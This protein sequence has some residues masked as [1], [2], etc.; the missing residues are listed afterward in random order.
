MKKKIM[1]T[2]KHTNDVLSKA[3]ELFDV[4]PTEEK[5]LTSEEILSFATTHQVVGLLVSHGQKFDQELIE[6]LPSSVKVIAT[7]SVGFDHLDLASAKKKQIV[8][9]NTPDVLSDA[10]A[11]LTM[12]LILNVSRRARE[13]VKIMDEGWRRSFGQSE[14]LGMDLNHKTLAIFGMGAIGR[15]VAKKARAFGMKIIYCNRKRLSPELE[16]GAQYFK[17]LEEMIPHADVLTLHAPATSETNFIMNKKTFSL[18][19]KTA[20]FINVARGNLVD[21][22]ALHEALEGN[23]IF[24]A[25]LDVFSHEPD[26][27]QKFLNYKNVFLTPHMGSATIETRN[28]MGFLALENIQ[29]VLE[30]KEAKTEIKS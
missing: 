25:G 15:D 12:M 30:G 28:A 6:K 29:N 27:D 7:S 19:K 4:I 3:Q 14:M 17:T 8:L 26:F 24:G 22:E 5:R 10:T 2:F 18:M 16:E 21:E 23:K 20:I 11:T 1:I 13:Y 9:T